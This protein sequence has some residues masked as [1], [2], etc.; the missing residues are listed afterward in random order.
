M[1]LAD[2]LATF[3]SYNRDDSEFALRLAEDLKAAGANV[4]IDQLDIPAGMQWDRMVEDALNSCPHMLVILSPISVKSDHVRDEVSF[5]LSKQKRVIPVLYRE[6]DVPFRMARLQHIDFRTDYARGLKLLLKAL[7][8]DQS[9]QPLAEKARVEQEEREGRK[10]EE[11]ARCEQA[12]EERDRRAELNGQSIAAAEQEQGREGSQGL[13]SRGLRL[14][15][16]LPVWLK[17]VPCGI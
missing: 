14:F 9:P 16:E 6:C 7:G 11:A 13:Y 4:W 2:P 8:V 5:A 3:F 1:V 17:I 12:W 10:A 15:S